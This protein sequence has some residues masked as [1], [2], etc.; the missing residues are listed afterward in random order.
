MKTRE[1]VIEFLKGKKYSLFDLITIQG[2]LQAKGID[3]NLEIREG[4][5]FLAKDFIDWFESES[6]E[7]ELIPN[8]FYFSQNGKYSWVIQFKEFIEDNQHPIYYYYMLKIH[9]NTLNSYVNCTR[10]GQGDEKRV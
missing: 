3:V 10:S 4:E 7:L 2:Y 6:K 9:D 5:L 1:E 8:E